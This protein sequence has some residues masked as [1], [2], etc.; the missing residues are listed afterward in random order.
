[1]SAPQILKTTAATA[2]TLASG[3]ALF[4]A[5]AGTAIA[6]EAGR[7]NSNHPLAANTSAWNYATYIQSQK[8]T[9]GFYLSNSWQSG[10]Y[11]RSYAGYPCSRYAQPAGTT[12]P[13]FIQTSGSLSRCSE[14]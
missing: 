14:Y 2:A 4:F 3:V 5:G 12:L 13:G 9:Y 1:M 11:Y 6:P 8:P 7:L 10:Y